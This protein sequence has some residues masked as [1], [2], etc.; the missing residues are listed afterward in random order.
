MV[1][2]DDDMVRIFVLLANTMTKAK[3][4]HA[5]RLCFIRDESRRGSESFVPKVDLALVRGNSSSGTNV[6]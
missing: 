6:S 1:G 2:F 4:M 3:S 5:S